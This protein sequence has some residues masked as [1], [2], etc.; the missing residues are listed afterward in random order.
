MI[1]A[2]EPCGLTSRFNMVHP[3]FYVDQG[4]RA[5]LQ[6]SPKSKFFKKSSSGDINPKKKKINTRRDIMKK[7]CTKENVTGKNVGRN[8]TKKKF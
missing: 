5:S 6:Y 8:E 3:K 2:L 1:S 4:A 7:S